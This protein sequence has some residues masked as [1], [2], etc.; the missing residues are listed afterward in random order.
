MPC[1]MNPLTQTKR[2]YYILPQAPTLYVGPN[3][4]KGHRSPMSRTSLHRPRRNRAVWDRPAPG[5]RLLPSPLPLTVSPGIPLPG[6]G[7]STDYMRHTLSKGLCRIGAP[8]TGRSG[9]AH[10]EFKEPAFAGLR[11]RAVVP[12]QDPTA[13]TIRVIPSAD[14]GIGSVLPSSRVVERSCRT[15][16]PH[17]ETPSNLA[18]LLRHVWGYS[19]IAA[20][21]EHPLGRTLGVGA[22]VVVFLFKSLGPSIASPSSHCVIPRLSEESRIC[23][24]TC[25]RHRPPQPIPNPEP[26]SFPSSG[27]PH[28][29]DTAQKLS[30]EQSSRHAF[31]SKNN[32]IPTVPTGCKPHPSGGSPVPFNEHTVRGKT[33]AYGIIPTPQF[34]SNTGALPPSSSQGGVRVQVSFSRFPIARRR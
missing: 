23:P 7:R 25:L 33:H 6:D 34:T 4:G 17:T 26:T 14:R 16:R 19:R 27:A 8:L 21:V 22:G 31:D 24:L 10:G 29:S 12:L 13:V 1:D 28:P 3:Q 20:D 5:T 11:L 18:R 15:D 2:M 9:F 30:L 32:Q